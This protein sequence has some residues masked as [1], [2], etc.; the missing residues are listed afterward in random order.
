MNA[1][2]SAAGSPI[3]DGDVLV[4]RIR[5][6]FGVSLSAL[7]QVYGG[8]D[9][10]AVVMRATTLE[11][12]TVAVKVSR[13]PRTSGVLAATV[14]AEQIP[15]G[16]PAPLRAR[17]GQPYSTVDAR[18]LSLTPWI[19]GRPAFE[20]GMG[21]RQWR[22]FGELLSRVH[23]AQLPAAVVTQLPAEDYR[24]PAAAMART[25]DERI[26]RRGPRP[27]ALA[28]AGDPLTRALI[29]DWR[30]AGDS[31]AVILAQI[32]DLGDELRG[33]PAPNVV[34]HGDAHTANVML[35]DHGQGWLLDWDDVAYAPRERDLM[36]V[37][38]GVLAHAPVSMQEQRW[39]FEGYGPA[40]IDPILLA[41]YRCSW[42][43]Q[44]VADYAT[45][46]LDQ[47][48]GPTPARSEALRLFRD[49][50]SPTGIV[51]LA[52]SSLYVEQMTR[53]KRSEDARD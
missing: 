15:L 29:H 30:A 26:R 22:S 7:S 43:L 20:T 2:A 6:E 35:D 31:L 34:C 33:G 46:I 38:G 49:V 16:I 44:D 1:F 48:A 28:G 23:A 50:L 21:A 42:A 9:A 19:A 39:F 13:N 53:T 27:H 36:F 52:L 8:Q 14:L 4:E 32:D 17:S 24:T 40:G 51:N 41:Y 12:A 5:A 11:G 47:P 45:R 10:D 37:L 25:L 18:T 3:I